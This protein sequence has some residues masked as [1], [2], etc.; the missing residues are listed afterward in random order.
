MSVYHILPMYLDRQTLA[1][2]VDPDQTP[3]SAVSDLDL[4]CLPHI[5][6]ILDISAG[7]QID[8][9]SFRTNMERERG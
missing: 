3:H 1:N 4:H 8:L 6:E 9:F 5:Q 2:N 7:S